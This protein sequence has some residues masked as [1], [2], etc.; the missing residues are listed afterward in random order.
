MDKTSITKNHHSFLYIDGKSLMWWLWLLN[1]RDAALLSG[2]TYD[3][4]DDCSV[5]DKLRMEKITIYVEHPRPIEP[6]A[7]T[8][9]L[10]P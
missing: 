3:E 4:I 9:P 10:P 2:G 5:S 7:E 1:F 8:A 6:P